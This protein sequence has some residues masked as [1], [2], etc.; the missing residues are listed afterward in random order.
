MHRD[1]VKPLRALAEVAHAV[2][3]ERAFHQRV[4]ATPLAEL[5]ELG[6]DFN[7]LLDEF[8]GWQNHLRAQNATLAHQAN[9]DPLTGLPNRAYFE[10]RLCRRWPTRVSSACRAA[11]PRQRPLQGNQRPAGP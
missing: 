11:L 10:S 9:H 2:R 7:A 5:K 8:E 3:R 1:I 4:A 6:D